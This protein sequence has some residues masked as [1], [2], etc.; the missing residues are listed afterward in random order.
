MTPTNGILRD[1]YW[2]LS[3]LGQGGMG[4]TYRVWDL[5]QRIP[6][7]VKMPREELRGDATTIRRFVHE[8]HAMLALKHPHI[9]PITDYGD[10]GDTPFVVMR[11]LPGGSLADHRMRDTSGAFLPSP[12]KTLR[13]WLEGIASALDFIHGRGVLHRDIKPANIFFDASLQALLGDFGLAKAVD[14]QHDVLRDR[15]LTAEHHAI[16][17]AEYMA[18]EHVTRPAS[19]SAYADQYSLG[20]TVYEILSGR[21]PFTGGS[22]N[23]FV[24]HA[25]LPLPQLN[26][27]ALKIPD[28][29]WMA[30]ERALAKQPEDRFPDCRAFASAAL[31]D[32]PPLRLDPSIAR[33]L[34]PQCA[35]MIRLNASAAGKSGR[36]PKCRAAMEVASDLSSMWLSTE[37]VVA[38]GTQDTKSS[39]TLWDSLA[40]SFSSLYSRFCEIWNTRVSFSTGQIA[41]AGVTL[42]A[43]SAGL[44]WSAWPTPD[45]VSRNSHEQEIDQTRETLRDREQDLL[46]REQRLALWESEVMKREREAVERQ[47]LSLGRDEGDQTRQQLL[48]QKE[49]FPDQNRQLPPQAEHLAQSHREPSRME[50]QL[51]ASSTAPNDQPEVMTQLE[52][53]TC[54]DIRRL[55]ERRQ[56]IRL[57]GLMT[58]PEKAADILAK[59]KGEL[60]LD[61]LRTLSAE[62]AKKLTQDRE[63]DLHLSGLQEMTDELAQ[64]LTKK[65]GALVLDGITQLSA[66]AARSLAIEYGRAGLLSLNGL[67]W[68]LIDEAKELAEHSGPLSLRGLDDL[69]I[70]AAEEFRKHKT[71]V[72]LDESLTNPESPLNRIVFPPNCTFL[73]ELR[74]YPD[75][76]HFAK[77]PA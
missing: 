56:P 55:V 7:V 35:S 10:D 68:L 58:L 69:S 60:Y 25:T 19:L 42:F 46:M 70:D 12:P 52:P 26:R 38:S 63:G 28:T 21:K 27:A 3:K 66:P 74:K 30:L 51:P 20:V 23:I 8:L 4:V 29:L 49:S 39:D 61:S 18:P 67:K 14:G 15:G 76:F 62:D 13:C 54:D 47:Q 5:H 2:I 64:C 71:S 31:R 36:C 37:K 33:F 40:S 57:D 17:T 11:Y 45:D 44:T 24:E 73:E 6:A 22:G 50:P 9:V 72:Y 59:H 16:G 75:I 1:R 43:L 77:P 48:P 34:C 65:R 53:F 41:L 32:V